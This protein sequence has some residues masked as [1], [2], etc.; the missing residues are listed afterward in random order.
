MSFSPFTI[1]FRMLST[2][3]LLTCVKNIT[4]FCTMIPRTFIHFFTVCSIIRILFLTYL[5]GIGCTFL[6]GIFTTFRTQL[7]S[8]LVLMT[9]PDF[10]DWLRVV[11]CPLLHRFKAFRAMSHIIFMIANLFSLFIRR[12]F[13]LSLCTNSVFVRFP[14]GT[15]LCRFIGFFLFRAQMRQIGAR[16]LSIL[17]PKPVPICDI[18]L[19]LVFRQF[20]A[21]FSNKEIFRNLMRHGANSRSWSRKIS[22][23]QPVR[24]TGCLVVHEATIS[25]TLIV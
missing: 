8:I 17:F 10:A 18:P 13:R 2:L 15:I 16:D 19:M 5:V 21:F 1:F 25:R 14:V 9:L 4:L 6:G 23:R 3:L 20:F 12:I 24:V 7:L 22:V 11:G